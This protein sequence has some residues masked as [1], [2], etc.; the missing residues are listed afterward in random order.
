MKLVDPIVLALKRVAKK[1]ER[2][3]SQVALGWLIAKG[4]VPIPGAKNK[5]Q[6]EDNAG[7]LT[8]QLD[9]DDLA[10]LDANALE[11]KRSLLNRYWQ[12]G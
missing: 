5:L 10:A 7:A 12:H 3:P 4:V 8:F 1:H 9:A 2:T 11:G 6:A